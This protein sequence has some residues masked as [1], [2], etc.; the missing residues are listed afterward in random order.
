MTPEDKI[1]KLE[2]AF[3]ELQDLGDLQ[4][5]SD[6]SWLRYTQPSAPTQFRN[7]VLRSILEPD[8]VQPRIE[9]TIRHFDDHNLPFRWIITPSSRP[10]DLPQ[11]LMANGFAHFETLRGVTA[12]PANFPPPDDDIEIVEVDERLVEDWLLVNRE[13]FGLP[14]QAVPRFRK[15]HLMRL[16]EEPRREYSFIARVDGEPASAGSFIRVEDFAHFSGAATRKSFQRRG[17]YRRLVLARMA[18]LRELGISLVTN[19]AVATTSGPLCMKMGFE[20]VCDFEVFV[21]EPPA[22]PGE[23]RPS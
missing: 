15:V 19:H 22:L 2:R 5:E 17:L 16:A 20:H 1:A 12:A 3:C 8:E 6:D 7:G 11:A 21:H 14:D 9:E 23:P 13:G 18:R 10:L 4:L